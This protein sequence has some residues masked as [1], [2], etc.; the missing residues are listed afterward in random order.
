MVA[1][2]DV[3]VY[4]YERCVCIAA[5][6]AAHL[7]LACYSL[8]V[9]LSVCRRAWLEQVFSVYARAPWRAVPAPLLPY[10]T[11][12]AGSGAPAAGW[13]QVDSVTMWGLA[14]LVLCDGRWINCDCGA[15][16]DR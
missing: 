13:Y 10:R 15:V 2:C 4:I 7:L 1:C 9:A 16:T 11:I 6:P 5:P 8:S 12:P 14:L 3:A